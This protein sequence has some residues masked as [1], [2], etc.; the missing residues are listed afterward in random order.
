MVGTV[1][2][3]YRNDNMDPVH[4]TGVVH[5]AHIK[6]VNCRATGGEHSYKKHDHKDT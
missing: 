3:A 1:D 4:Y 5:S 6:N 2:G